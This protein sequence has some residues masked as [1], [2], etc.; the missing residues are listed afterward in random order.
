[1]S[2]DVRYEDCRNCWAFFCC[3]EVWYD[4][5]DAS[6]NYYLD[7]IYITNIS[8]YVSTRGGKIVIDGSNF[9][10]TYYISLGNAWWNTPLTFSST[11]ITF[12]FIQNNSENAILNF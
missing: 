7:F 8:D 2:D 1:M 12:R 10:T 5:Y 9:T 6:C 3:D 11:K 4:H